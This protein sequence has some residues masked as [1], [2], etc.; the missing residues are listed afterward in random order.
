M[1]LVRAAAA[2]QVCSQKWASSISL[3]VRLKTLA[4]ERFQM[5]RTRG[6]SRQSLRQLDARRSSATPLAQR[7]TEA[8]P[9]QQFPSKVGGQIKR[10]GTSNKFSGFWQRIIIA[11]DKPVE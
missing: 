7:T 8:V 3:W 6:A 5:P 10:E 11:E 9:L 1:Q 4:R 2:A